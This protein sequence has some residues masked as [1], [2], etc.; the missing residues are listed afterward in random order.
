MSNGPTQASAAS[1]TIARQ[2]R[3]GGDVTANPGHYRRP[4]F[5]PDGKTIVFEK[6]SGGYL[7]SS[8]RSDDPG[9]YRIAAAGGA[10][11]KVTGDG[12]YPAFRRDQRPHLPDAHREAGRRAGLRRPQRRGRAHA[13]QGRDGGGLRGL[14][15]RPASSA[16][17]DNFAAYVMPLAAGPQEVGAGKGGSAMP[18]VKASAG[19]AT[20]LSLVGR[21]P[22]TQL[23]PWADALLGQCRRDD[24]ARRRRRRARS[25]ALQA[26]ED[27]RRSLDPRDGREAH[28]HRRA[29]RRAHRHHGGRRGRRDRERHRSSSPTT[30]SRRS[31]RAAR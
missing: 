10:M 31:A 6:G 8:T 29:D 7:L 2:R 30:A 28:G 27:R 18:V 26:A 4:R 14:A 12:Q 16:F 19:G 24:A 11:T 13:C 1:R 22:A 5:S 15:R 23:E 9:V 3:R 17:R 25:P 21:R 20:Y